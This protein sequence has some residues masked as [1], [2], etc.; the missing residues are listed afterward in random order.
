MAMIPLHDFGPATTCV[1][2]LSSWLT[3]VTRDYFSERDMADWRL[4]PRDSVPGEHMSQRV[5]GS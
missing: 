5:P 1:A 2:D 3:N 4:Q